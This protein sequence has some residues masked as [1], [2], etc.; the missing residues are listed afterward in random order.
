MVRITW[1]DGEPPKP[2]ARRQSAASSNF[3]YQMWWKRCGR[4]HQRCRVFARG[5]KNSVGVEFE[6]GFRMVIS[7]NSL[8]VA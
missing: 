8:R 5:S 1:L 6:D 2:A 4:Q 3:P 7:G